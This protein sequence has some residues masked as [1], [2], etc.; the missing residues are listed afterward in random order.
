MLDLGATIKP[1][2]KIPKIYGYDAKAKKIWIPLETVK[3]EPFES[4]ISYS[5]QNVDYS[6]SPFEPNVVNLRKNP[7]GWLESIPR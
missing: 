3:L 7:N 6:K 5:L 4:N 2:E 1:F